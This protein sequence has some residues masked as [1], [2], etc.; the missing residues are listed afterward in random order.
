M[1]VLFKAPAIYQG[2]KKNPVEQVGTSKWEAKGPSGF[3]PAA[4][5]SESAEGGEGRH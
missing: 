1:Y 3:Q 4:P 5:E 2:Y